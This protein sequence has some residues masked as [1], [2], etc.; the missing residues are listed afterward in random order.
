MYD[1]PITAHDEA[2]HFWSSCPDIPEA[3]SAGDTIEELLANAVDGICLAL[4][5]YVDQVR[6]IPPASPAG[7]GQHVVHLPAQAV[8][9]IAL[10]N[11]MREQGLRVADLARLLEVSHPVASRLVDFDHT[12]KM[13]QIERALAA[14]GKRLA[15]SVEAA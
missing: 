13:E 6:S 9:K 11:T 1:Y 7:E 2:G 10:W 3:H 12:S 8:A 5:I 4:T 14:L 15:V